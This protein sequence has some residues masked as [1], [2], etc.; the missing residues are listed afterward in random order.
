MLTTRYCRHGYVGQ[1]AE[2]TR[3]IE[4]DELFK[5]PENDD[6]IGEVWRRARNAAL[7]MR[8]FCCQ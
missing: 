7:H 2:L 8:G 3:I 1:V 6:L 5:Y 4:E